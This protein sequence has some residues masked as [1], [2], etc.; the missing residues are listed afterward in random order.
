VHYG[1]LS[2]RFHEDDFRARSATIERYGAGAIPEDSSLIDWPL[3]YADL[4]PFYDRAEYDLGVS[5]KAG[6]LQGKTIDGGNVFEAPRGR[7][8][9][10]PPLQ[11][12]QSGIVFEAGARKL[13]YHPFPSPR[14]FISQAYR[15]RPG[16]TYCGFCQAFGC[17][18][19]AKSSTLVTKLPEADAIATSSPDISPATPPSRRR[20]RTCPTRTRPSTSIPI[21]IRAMPGAC[22][23]RA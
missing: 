9:P 1:S 4:E 6:N 15:G 17:H 13:G 14:A 3:R 12:D 2:W 19:G 10:L 20:S 11:S 21:P 23:R 22:R 18:V 16:C 7:D 5:G 8:Y